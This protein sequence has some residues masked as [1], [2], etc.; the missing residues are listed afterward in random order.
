MKR[1]MKAIAIT[2]CIVFVLG[3]IMT[4]VDFCRLR[5]GAF[6]P[7]IFTT[8]TYLA[9]GGSSRLCRGLFHKIVIDGNFMPDDELPGIT[10]YTFYIFGIKVDEGIRD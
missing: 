5:Y 4:A 2:L 3:S 1:A 8:E 6:E 10:H 7:P 9:D